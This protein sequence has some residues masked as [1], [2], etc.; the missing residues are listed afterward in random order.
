MGKSTLVGAVW[1]S[2]V[3]WE[4]WEK[5]HPSTHQVMVDRSWSQLWTLRS[6]NWFQPLLAMVQKPL[7]NTVFDN[8][9]WTREPLCKSRFPAAKFQHTI[10]EKNMSLDTSERVRGIV[11][12]YPCHPF[13]RWH[14]SVPGRPSQSMVLPT[15]STWMSSH[16]PQLYRMLP[17]R[18]ISLSHPIQSTELW[19]AWLGGGRGWENSR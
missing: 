4:T 2:T 7:E 5:Y 19:A 15:G 17:K 12:L 8:H 10:E 1:F 3:W 13:P 11:G 16:L 6:I 14:S 18:T 9:P